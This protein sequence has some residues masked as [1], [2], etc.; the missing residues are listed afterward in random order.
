[1]SNGVTINLSMVEDDGNYS[2]G[3]HYND[4]AGHDFTIEKESEDVEQMINEL[5]TEVYEVALNC[6]QEEKE[7]TL[8]ELLEENARLEEENEKLRKKIKKVAY[9]SERGHSPFWDIYK[10][11]KWL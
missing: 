2:V 8:E 5:V 4:T 11:Y 3:L 9:S 10:E 6:L 7:P 1:M